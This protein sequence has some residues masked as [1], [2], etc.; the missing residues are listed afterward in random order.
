[1]AA[2]LIRDAPPRVHDWLKAT[3][4]ENRRSLNQQIIVCLE[5]C[6]QKMPREATALPKP[7]LLKGA[8]L[9]LDELDHV[10]KAGRK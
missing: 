1:M 7:V 5:W 9:T 10:R 2:M 8:S 4:S 3:A 6:M